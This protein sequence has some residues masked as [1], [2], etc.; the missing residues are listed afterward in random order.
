MHRYLRDKRLH[1][2]GVYERSH[3]HGDID[4]RR[5]M[6]LPPRQSPQGL[7]SIP[8]N[9]VARSVDGKKPAPASTK[10]ARSSRTAT[11][12]PDG[13]S[14]SRAGG[15]HATTANDSAIVD[16][17]SPMFITLTSNGDRMRHAECRQ[18]SALGRR[19]PSVRKLIAGRYCK[20]RTR[21]G[22]AT[23]GLAHW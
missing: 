5:E 13:S 11:T 17:Q 4:N 3:L 15:A 2:H 23:R 10:T 1:L 14:T 7:E 21:P 12:V 9:F 16:P 19:G 22:L 18:G 6:G 8:A 20:K